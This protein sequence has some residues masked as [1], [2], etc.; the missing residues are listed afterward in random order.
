VAEKLTQIREKY[1]PEALTLF[2]HGYGSSWFK[3]PVKAYGSNNIAAPS[4]A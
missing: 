4:D 3:H 2:S 1:G